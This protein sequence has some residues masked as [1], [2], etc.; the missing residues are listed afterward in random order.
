L[1]L[2]DLNL[3]GI[4]GLEVL[5]R[6]KSESKTRDIPVIVLTV[7]QNSRHIK[8]SRQLGAANYIVKP[9]DFQ[10]FSRV[11]PELSMQWA[12]LQTPTH[13]FSSK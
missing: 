4:G 2:L 8:A 11:T 3:P 7:S 5:E 1:I 12:L 10:N 13:E 9:V 6:I